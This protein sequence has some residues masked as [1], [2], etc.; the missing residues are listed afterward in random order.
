MAFAKIR[1]VLQTTFTELLPW[2]SLGGAFAAAAAASLVPVILNSVLNVP[3]IVLLPV[4][5]MVY[6]V[7]YAALVLIAGLLSEEEIEAIKKTLYLW[8]RRRSAESA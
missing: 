5:G 1:Q 3:G 6:V 7:T 4:S 2:K 8:N